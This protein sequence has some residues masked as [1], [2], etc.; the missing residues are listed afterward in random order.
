MAESVLP[1]IRS[2][3]NVDE[4]QTQP[5]GP[6]TS[7]VCRRVTHHGI[8]A[9]LPPLVG[10]LPSHPRT[11]RPCTVPNEHELTSPNDTFSHGVEEKRPPG[12]GRE[13]LSPQYIPLPSQETASIRRRNPLQRVVLY[14]DAQNVLTP[15]E[16]LSNPPEGPEPPFNS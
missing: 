15:P 12:L 9:S 5:R 1:S 6:S 7:L 11:C 14:K 10:S 2:L 3:I 8:H 13:A 16:V 4:D